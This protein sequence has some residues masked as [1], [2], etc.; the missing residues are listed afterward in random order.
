MTQTQIRLRAR[1]RHRRV[2]PGGLVPIAV[3]GALL[4]T[5]A[6]GAAVPAPA[7][8]TPEPSPDRHAGAGSECNVEENRPTR[9]D[10]VTH[11]TMDASSPA[12]DESFLLALNDPIE[13][14]RYESRWKPASLV[15]APVIP[16]LRPPVLGGLRDRFVNADPF[17][18]TLLFTAVAAG[19]GLL[20]TWR[21]MTLSTDASIVYAKQRYAPN[22]V[23]STEERDPEANR[24][25]GFAQF[26]SARQLRARLAP[27]TPLAL[28]YRA[29]ILDLRRD[30]RYYADREQS[31][32]LRWAPLDL[33]PV[34]IGVSWQWYQRDHGIRRDG[35][36][37]HL[38]L[39]R[40]G[41]FVE[42]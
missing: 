39:V 24:N 37:F 3:A 38:R 16:Y 18:D 10:C 4:A 41:L 22:L 25:Y 8:A 26:G 32:A 2:G 14:F 30:G 35:D 42:L 29:G 17:D 28:E 34:R 12:F 6:V 20:A 15:D 13:Y 21:F 9:H 40:T 7:P 31:A 11:L 1:A 27:W 36:S 33:G 5:P 23:H 19:G